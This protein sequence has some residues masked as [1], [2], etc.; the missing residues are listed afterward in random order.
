MLL[1]PTD[2]VVIKFGRGNPPDTTVKGSR[3]GQFT[4]ACASCHVFRT[5]LLSISRG[6]C[7]HTNMLVPQSVSVNQSLSHLAQANMHT[8]LPVLSGVMNRMY[9]VLTAYMPLWWDA[10]CCLIICLCSVLAETIT[11]QLCTLPWSVTVTDC[12]FWPDYQ[13]TVR[14]NQVML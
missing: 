1:E 11:F 4:S 3:I 6:A 8:L 14:L 13:H 10:K 12:V 9:T 2:S 7:T 5:L